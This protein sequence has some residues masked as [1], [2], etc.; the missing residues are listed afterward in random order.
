M[1][2]MIMI[3]LLVFGLNANAQDGIELAVYQDLK[4]ATIGDSERGYK[5]GTTDVVLRLRMMGFQ[6]R[7]G[8]TI[9]FPEYEYAD[10]DGTY[11]RYGA[12]VGYVLNQLVIENL[13]VD[14]TVSYGFIDRYSKTFF[15]FGLTSSLNYD[16]GGL[17]ISAKGQLTQRNDLK[18]FYS[19][20]NI[21]KP[22][23][24]IGILIKL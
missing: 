4:F 1:K 10:I 19:E 13:E 9:V 6:D 18:A 14:A 11:K 3:M 16:L 23:F 7:Y 15:S 20:S 2:S 8:Y 17:K 12:G 21:W 5:A 22:S 24:F